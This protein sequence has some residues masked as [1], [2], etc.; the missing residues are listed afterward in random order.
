MQLNFTPAYLCYI[1]VHRWNR[2]WMT[3]VESGWPSKR[4][5]LKQRACSK[6]TRYVHGI[7]FSLV[8]T[9][10]MNVNSLD[11]AV[12]VIAKPWRNSFSRYT[13]VMKMF[14]RPFVDLNVFC[15]AAL[16]DFEK[17]NTAQ[18]YAWERYQ[19]TVLY[20]KTHRM[21]QIGKIS[22]RQGNWQLFSWV[23]L[24]TFTDL[25]KQTSGI[26]STVKPH[27]SDIKTTS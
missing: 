10:H 8:Q 7:C 4:N 12:V 18:I 20:I 23:L 15:Q 19:W 22:F 3:W 16:P 14:E 26:L 1:F 5:S 2:C 6:S 13:W 27:H 21:F 11:V 24:R 25:C 9:K 17:Q